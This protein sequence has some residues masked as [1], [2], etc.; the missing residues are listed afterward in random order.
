MNFTL[1]Y[2]YLLTKF[3][4]SVLSTAN[5]IVSHGKDC[6]IISYDMILAR[7][8][9]L[10]LYSINNALSMQ[11]WKTS[12]ACLGFEEQYHRKLLRSFVKYQG[13][14]V[15]II[16]LWYVFFLFFNNVFIIAGYLGCIVYICSFDC[17]DFW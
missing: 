5:E 13:L 3:N 1:L 17:D 12:N 4:C 9:Q 11:S 10:F 16:S 14:T 7:G 8:A 2:F 6:E 15:K